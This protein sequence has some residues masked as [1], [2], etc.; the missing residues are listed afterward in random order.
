VSE[1]GFALLMVTTMLLILTNA[2]TDF[3]FQ[4]QINH[5]IAANQVGRAQAYYLAKSGLNFSK[6]LLVYNKQVE[7]QL[8]KVKSNPQISA[9]IGSQPIYKLMP[10]SSAF[11]RTALAG[12]GG[13]KSTE[14]SSDTGGETDGAEDTSGDTGEDTAGADTS[15][16]KPMNALSEADAKE[17]LDFE[18]DFEAEINEE[19]SKFSLNA[20]AKLTTSS[21]SYDMVKKVIYNMLLQPQFKNYFENHEVDSERLTHAIADYVDTN[22]VINEF[23]KV[24][25][26]QEDASYKNAK[27]LTASELRLVAGMNDDIFAILEPMITVYHTATKVNACLAKES[28]VDAIIVQFTTAAECTTPIKSDET[29]KVRELRE[30]LIDKC[31]EGVTSMANAVYDKLGIKV[32]ASDSSSSDSES[33]DTSTSTSTS[34]SSSSSSSASSGCKVKLEDMITDSNT[35]FRIKGIGTVNDVETAITEVIDASASK[36]A[37]WKTLYYH[38]D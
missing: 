17:F 18:G 21:A 12:S 29:D 26:G 22:T 32:T 34:S 28:L 8:E 23:D 38:V 14:E 7:K 11:L 1:R 25:R 35:I 30:A 15:A 36:A 37:K 24:E 33:T 3:M 6:L 5:E 9:L 13:S 19:E 10:L 31:D 20:V 2:V 16:A 4:T 27:Y